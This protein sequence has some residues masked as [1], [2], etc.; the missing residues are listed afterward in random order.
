LV[1][2]RTVTGTQEPDV[3]ALGIAHVMARAARL[4]HFEVVPVR[5]TEPITLN[6]ARDLLRYVEAERL[7]SL[8]V[9]TPLFRS[10]RSALV[11]GRTL[12]RAGVALRYQPVPGSAGIATWTRTWHGVQNVAQQWFKL[13]YY[14]LYVLPRVAWGLDD[15]D[16]P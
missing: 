10:R 4:D 3:V 16:T 1:P 9:V 5:V 13:Q 12:G 7:R 14:R 6:T 11:F 2:V 15:H 8:V